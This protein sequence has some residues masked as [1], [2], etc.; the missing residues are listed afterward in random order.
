MNPCGN[1]T[2][3][4]HQPCLAYL[5]SQSHKE[6]YKC[7]GNWI[8][9]LHLIMGH[10]SLLLSVETETLKSSQSSSLYLLFCPFLSQLHEMSAPL[11]SVYEVIK[12][13][14]TC[15]VKDVLNQ[16]QSCTHTLW[17]S[18]AHCPADRLC[19]ICTNINKGWTYTFEKDWGMIFY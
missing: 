17:H 2:L 8:G 4:G 3:M 15:L 1:V 7:T 6:P 14:Q 16:S 9:H 5:K 12:D 13:D 11:R 10:L 18:Q 19:V